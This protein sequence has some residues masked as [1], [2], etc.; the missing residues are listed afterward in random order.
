M[1]RLKE[2]FGKIKNKVGDKIDDIQGDLSRLKVAAAVGFVSF[3][4]SPDLTVPP[5]SARTD[6]PC[7]K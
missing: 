5:G 1:S 3:R 7:M 2:K 6:H 4:F